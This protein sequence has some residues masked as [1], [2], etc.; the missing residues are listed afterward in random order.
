MDDQR[1]GRVVRA[2]RHRRGWRQS[3]LAD[4]AG[5][6]QNLMSLIER[7]HLDRISLRVLRRVFAA[8]DA[9]ALIELRWRGAGVD[10]LLDEGHAT[11][12]GAVVMFL[13]A[14]GWLVEIEV[15]YSEYGERGSFDLLAFHQVTGILLVIEIKT[16]LPSA[17]ATLRKLDEK[18][19]LAIG[20]AGKR[21]DWRPKSVSRLLV[22]PESS[23]LR[24]RA[25]RHA[26]LFDRS[27]PARNVAIG[28][29][30]R[31]PSGT[32]LG[33]WFFSDI[34]SRVVIS[35]AVRRE[36]V[37]RPKSLPGNPAVAA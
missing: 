23:T 21:F 31:R 5:C 12:V 16:D 22:M 26:S 25:A 33:L 19:R 29:W 24:R 14:L 9:T 35:T 15:T 6:S 8:L 37:R 20:V 1:V 30:L 2:L 36:R 4:A 34:D 13:R 10:R 7:G 3:D 28:R 32:L 11:L 27:L 17:E 18:S